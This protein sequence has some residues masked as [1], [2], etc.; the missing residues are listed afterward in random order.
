MEKDELFIICS[1][2]SFEHQ[3]IFWRWD[4]PPTLYANFHLRTDKNF[5][6][7]LCAG[8]KYAFGHKCRFGNW[9]EFIF[10]E[11]QLKQLKDFLNEQIL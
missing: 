8:L 3:V 7:R 6:R 5:F 4:D 1:C 11:K 10:E 2:H 9:D